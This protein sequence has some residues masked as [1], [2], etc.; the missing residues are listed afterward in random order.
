M[1]ERDT[2]PGLSSAAR[3][4][5]D[6]RRA[7][8]P[9]TLPS[10]GPWECENPRAHERLAELERDMAALTA[11]SVRLLADVTGLSEVSGMPRELAAPLLKDAADRLRATLR[12][13]GAIAP[14]GM[15]EGPRS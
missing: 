13:L 3:P 8:S 6:D 2:G 5:T 9:P 7:V 14:A 4:V 1:A 15:A 12:R 11:D 10:P